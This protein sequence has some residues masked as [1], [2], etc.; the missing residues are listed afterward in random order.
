[1]VDGSQAG[2]GV[3]KDEAAGNDAD[4]GAKNEGAQRQTGQRR[5]QVDQEERVI[6]D[7]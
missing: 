7:N 2:S 5:R 3:D 1:M 4:Q 6:S